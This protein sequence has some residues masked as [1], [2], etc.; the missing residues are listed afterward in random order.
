MELFEILDLIYQC[1]M[2]DKSR[3]LFILELIDNMMI[4]EAE[5]PFAGLAEDTLNR[6]FNGT[7]S[8]PKRKAK[9]IYS[10]KDLTRLVSY[11][12]NMEDRV[13]YN[14]EDEIQ[15]NDISYE[16]DDSCYNLSILLSEKM[17]SIY[18]NK[19]SNK[20]TKPNII[21]E[22][23]VIY[24]QA[25]SFCIEHEQEIEFLPLC[26]IAAF[27]NPMHKYV[28]QMYTDFCKCSVA[29]KKKIL[30]INGCKELFFSNKTWIA[31]SLDLFDN[32]IHERKLCTSN[33]LYEDAKYLHRAF[34]IYSE[35]PVEY[36]P[37]IFEPLIKS[38]CNALGKEAKCSLYIWISD[39]LKLISNN[40]ETNM[41]PPLD[42][43]WTYCKNSNVQEY[44]VTYWVCMSIIATCPQLGNKVDYSSNADEH[45]LIDVDLGDSEGLISSQEDM[46]LYALLELYKYFQRNKKV[47]R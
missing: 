14:I 4:K 12:N 38:E 11:L 26:Q 41:I 32:E 16:H 22:D 17:H 31:E 30:Q 42:S 36:N 35:Y 15:K 43:M 23:E 27:L 3:N 24:R 33:F 39:Y 29:V 44:E 8:F 20:Q 45:C 7:N 18:D 37:W 46:Y 9:Y 5:N 21:E 13:I 40:P 19:Q 10:H 2:T 25:Q 34:E 47:P 6:I 1:A 28:R